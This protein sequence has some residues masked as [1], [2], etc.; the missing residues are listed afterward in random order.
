MAFTQ[1][2]H[3]N[4]FEKVP[5]SSAKMRDLDSN[6]DSLFW[7]SCLMHVSSPVISRT[8]YHI[9]YLVLAWVL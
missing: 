8:I 9:P 2:I 5:D 7:V 3:S 6:D 4:I 1:K